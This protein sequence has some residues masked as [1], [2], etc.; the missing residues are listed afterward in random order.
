[1]EKD[2]LLAVVVWLLLQHERTIAEQVGK[3]DRM[4]SEMQRMMLK[5]VDFEKLGLQLSQQN[6]SIL[7]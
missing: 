4:E 5:L 1:M 6:K 2:E 3:I 7:K